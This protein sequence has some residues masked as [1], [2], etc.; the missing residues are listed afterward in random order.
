[1]TFL[2]AR[3]GVFLR[4]DGCSR[5]FSPSTLGFPSQVGRT[6]WANVDRIDLPQHQWLPKISE[7]RQKIVNLDF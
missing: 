4:V 5:Q 7:M 3:N 2:E 1:M 6:P